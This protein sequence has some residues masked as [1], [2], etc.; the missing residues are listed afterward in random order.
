MLKVENNN[1]QLTDHISELILASIIITMLFM[2]TR[3][4]CISSDPTTLRNV[5]DV[6]LATALANKVFPKRILKKTFN[7]YGSN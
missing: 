3:Y 2:F 6:W 1:Q 7:I 4:F 5:A